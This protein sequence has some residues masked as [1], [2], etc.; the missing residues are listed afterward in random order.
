M[1]LCVC[2]CVCI[3]K[4]VYTEVKV[5]LQLTLLWWYF[6]LSQF[7]NLVCDVKHELDMGNNGLQWRSRVFSVDCSH[8][9]TGAT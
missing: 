7:S 4:I 6:E 3:V 1:F 2:V 5:E 8:A 9:A